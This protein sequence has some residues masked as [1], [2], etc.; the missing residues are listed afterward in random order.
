MEAESYL[1][2]VKD[3][4]G[5]LEA[6][7]GIELKNRPP[8]GS[9]DKIVVS[10][11]GGSSIAG[12]ILQSYM[13]KSKIPVFLSRDY[14][15]PEFAD[16]NTLVFS[17]SYSGNTEETISALRTAFGKGCTVIAVTSG[18][19]LLR[20][21]MEEKLPYLEVPSGLQPRASLAYQLVPVLKVLGLLGLIPDPSQD[22]RKAIA[23]LRDASYGDQAKSLAGK[24]TGRVPIVYASERLYPVAYRWKTQFNE[25]SKIHAFSGAFSEINHNELVGYSNLNASYHVIILEDQED[26]R[27]IRARIGLTKKIISEKEVP[28]TQIMIRGDNILTRL[29]SAVHIGDLT[30]VYLAMLTNTDPEPVEII[31]GFKASLEKIPDY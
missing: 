11:M 10:G 16:R 14:S 5:Q 9:Y 19:K 30:S 29:L 17:V 2:T 8:P 26:H 21:F 23:A 20:K 3:I 7:C 31:E 27:R 24:L 25:N 1:E 15:V 6:A 28:S 4:S 22:V 13:W 12:A 18:G